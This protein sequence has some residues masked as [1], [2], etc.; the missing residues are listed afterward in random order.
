MKRAM[1]FFS[2]FAAMAAISGVAAA[3]CACPAAPLAAP[4]Y[5]RKAQAAP[6]RKIADKLFYARLGE[7]MGPGAG[8]QGGPDL[9]L[10]LRIELDRVGIDASMNLGV[11]QSGPRM[12]ITGYRGS[13][14]QITTHYFLM[15]E[16]DN[17]PYL[18]AGLSWG[19]RSEEISGSTYAGSGL[20]GEL[21]AG[22][23]FLRE[24]N[25]RIFVQAG[26]T[27]PMYMASTDPPIARFRG[28]A[29]GPLA[30]EQRYLPTMGLSVGIG[31]GRVRPAKMR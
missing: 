12:S 27:M 2:T 23:E 22:W 31:W 9:G 21:V 10:G 5:A 19:K 26:A 13:L 16:S 18:G 30:P 15:P 8:F 20:Q 4:K 7:S 24:S 6:L 25:T 11:T 1:V 28:K 17:S 29:V 14:L 3:E